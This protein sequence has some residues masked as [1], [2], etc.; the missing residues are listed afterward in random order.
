MDRLKNHR[1]RL[2]RVSLSAFPRVK[3]WTDYRN[4]IYAEAMIGQELPPIL[5]CGEKWL[6]GRNRVWALHRAKQS[7]VDCIDLAEIGLCLE[8]HV[9]GK[10]HSE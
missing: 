10:L 6:D 2:R 7:F 1:F 3:M 5:L 4:R 9:L 8:N